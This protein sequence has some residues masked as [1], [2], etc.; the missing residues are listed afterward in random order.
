MSSLTFRTP[1]I[2]IVSTVTGGLLTADAEYWVEQVRATVRF[3]DGVREL[4]DRGVRT[5]LEV[6]PGGVLAAMAQESLGD[7]AAAFATLRKDVAEPRAVVGAAGRLHVRGIRLDWKALMPGGRRVDLPVYAFQ[8]ERYWLEAT[9]SAADV[10]SVGLGAAN[11]PLLGAA[12]FRADGEGVLLTGRI[13]L[14]THSWLAD[15]TVVGRVLLPGTAFVELALRA[16]DEVGCGRVDELIVRAPLVLPERDGVQIQVAVAGPDEAGRCAFTVYARPDGDPEWSQHATGVLAVETPTEPV[17]LAAWPPPGAAAIDVGDLYPRLAGSGYGYG[18]VF[19][20][21]RAAWHGD[22]E[23]YAEVRLPSPATGSAAAFGLHPALSDAALHALGMADLGI[24][25]TGLPFSFTGVTL[26]AAAATELRARL[27]PAGPDAISVD[28]ADAAGRPVAT[29]ERLALRPMSDGPRPHHDAL[30]RLDWVPVPPDATEAAGEDAQVVEVVGRRPSGDLA[31]DVHRATAEALDLIQGRPLDAPGRLVFVTRGAVA[32]A[33]GEDVTDLAGAAVWGLVRS[34]QAENPGRFALIDLD[35][36]GAAAPPAAVASGE[37]QIAVRGGVAHV[38]RLARLATA[39]TLIPPPVPSWRLEATGTGTVD[40]LDLVDDPA[41]TRD[42]GPGEVRVAMRAAGLNFRDVVVTLGLVPGLNGVGGEGAGVVL[43]TGPGVTSMRPGDEVLGLIPGSGGPVA[44]TDARFLTRKP[45]GWSWERAAAVPIVYLTAYYGLVDLAG[46]TAGERVLIHAA[47]GGVGFAA[48]QLA[49]HLGLEVFGTASAGKW[50][51]LR[52]NG[53]D[54][55]HIAGSR[56]LDF[57]REFLGVTGGDG[58]DVVLDCLAGEFVDA[59]LRLLPHGG[60]FLELGKTDIRDPRAV[61]ERYPGVSY[62]AYDLVEAAGPDR[63]Q[64]MLG[65]I[66]TL[67]ERGELSPPPVTTWDVR[68]AREAVRSLSQAKLVGKAVLTMPARLDPRGTVLVTGGTGTLGALAARHLVTTHGA[69]R[70]VLTSRRGAAAPG[71]GDLAAELSGMGAE[72]TV[73]A[74]DVADRESLAAVLAGIPAA[75]PLT[76]VV[77]TAG[78]VDDGLLASLT[79]ERLAAVLRP[80]VDAVVNLHEL[81]CDDELAEFV[82]FS[83][84]ASVIGAAGQGNYAAANAFLDAFARHRHALGRPATAVG[85][86]LWDERSGMTGHLT[87]TDRDRMARA[88]LL[89][90]SSDEG[91]ALF[92]AARSSVQAHALAMRLDLA[93]LHTA[94]DSVPPLLSGLVAAPGRR[95]ARAVAGTADRTGFA[96]R[97]AAMSETEQSALLTDLVCSNAATVLG[98]GPTATVDVHRPFRD[99]GFDSLTAVELRNRLGGATGLRL[100]ATAVFDH[101]TPAALVDHLRAELLGGPAGAAALPAAVVADDDPIVIVSMSCRYPGGVHT[102]ED[103]WQVVAGETDAVSDFPTDRGWDVEALYDPD[104]GVAGRTYAIEGGFLDDV[105]G[106]D[107][108]FFG[109]SPREAVAM[110]P[111]QRLLLETAWEAFERA[112]IDPVALRGSQTGVFAGVMLNDY[113]TRLSSVPEGVEG[114]LASGSSASVASGRIS[115]T[116]GLVGPAVTV[117]TA[118]SSSLVALHLAAQAL[119]QGECSLALAGGVTVMATPFAFVE[120]S[121]QRGLAADGRCKSFSSTADGTGWSEGAG[122][123]LLERRS[124]AER[125]GHEILAVVRGS[126][127]NQDG[128][129]NGLTAPNGPSQQRVIRQALA[130]A[131]LAPAD[132]DVVEAHGTGT[133]LGDPIEA[134][135][136]LA[137]YGQDRDQPLL[138]GS[139]KSNIGHTQAAAGVAGIIKMVLAMRHGVVPRTLHVDK[140]TPEVDWSSGAVELATAQVPWPAVERARRAAVSS[141]GVS[142]TNAHV[143]LE[144]LPEKPEMPKKPTGVLVPWVVS[145]KTEEGVRAQA[146]RLTAFVAERPGLDPV[147]VG[148]TLASRSPFEYRAVVGDDLVARAQDVKVVFVFPGQGS[149]WVGM[150]VELLDQSPVF[151]KSIEDCAAALSEFVDWSLVE[152]LRGGGSEFER[153]DV[154]QPALWAVM[155]SLAELWRSYGVAPDAVVGHSQGEIAAAVVAGALSHQDGARVVALRSRALLRI[156][157]A[158]GMLSIALPADE[159]GGR[160][161]GG[162]VGIAAY[163]GPN[164]VV[165]SGP[166]DALDEWQVELES[167]GVRARR[168]PVDYA[169]HSADVEI[170][171]EEILDSLAAVVPQPGRI[172]FYS[173]LTGELFDTSGLDAGYWFESLRQPVLFEQAT[174]ALTADGHGV[175]IE[176]SAHP[177]LTIGVPEIAVGSLRRDDG[178]LQRFLTS[179][180]EAWTHGVEVDW[181]QVYP[182]GRRVELPTYAFRHQRYWLDATPP[183]AAGEAGHPLLGTAVTLAGDGGVVMTGTLSLRTHPWLADHTVLDRVL[184]PGTAFVE[185]ALRAAEEAGCDRLDEIVIHAPLPLPERGSVHLQVVVAAPDESGGRALTVYAREDENDEWTRHATGHLTSGT[186]AEPPAL[187]TWPPPGAEAVA[188]ADLYPRLAEAGYGYGPVFQGLTS[189]WRAVDAVYAEVRLPL[190]AADSAAE[191]GLHPALFDAALHALGRSGFGPGTA[192][193]PFSFSGVALHATGAPAVRVRMAPAGSDAVS[194]ELADGAGRPV[195]S[196]ER[197]VVRPVSEAA[198]APSPHESLFRV[199]WVPVPETG[200]DG[201]ETVLVERSWGSSVEDVHTATAEALGLV[202][203]WLAETKPGRLVFVTRGAVAAV[204]GDDVTDPAGAAVWGLVRSAEAENPGRFALVDLDGDGTVRL[205][206]GEPQVAVRRGKVLAPRLA[207]TAADGEPVRLDPRG[208]VLVTGGTGMLGGLIARHLVSA[209]GVRNLMLISRRG[210]H[211]PGVDDLVADLAERGARA[212]VVA[213]DAA[214][215]EALAATLATIPAEHPLTAIVH[216]AGVLDDALLESTTRQRLAAVLRPKVDAAVN[217]AELTE[218]ERLA[219]FVLFSSAAAVL[220]GAGQGAYAAANAFLDAFAQQ[221]QA[222]GAIVSSLG[223]GL[224]APP[225]EMTGHLDQAQAA[226]LARAAMV[227][228][229]GEEGL[230]LFDAALATGAAHTVPARVNLATLRRDGAI[231]PLLS[232]LVARTG[233]RAASAS[234]TADPGLAERLAGMPEAEGSAYLLGLVRS[235]VAT[236]LGRVTPDDVDAGRAFKDL[237][238]DSLTAVDLRNRLGAATGLRLPATVVFDHPNATGLAG[239]LRAELLAEATGVEPLLAELDRLG[240]SLGAVTA[241]PAERTRITLRLRSLMTAWAG[242]DDGTPADDDDLSAATDDELFQLADQQLGLS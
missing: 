27:K 46:A 74:C 226:R 153:V 176:C 38:P 182:Q 62:R 186:P 202:Q 235:H 132:V 10:T 148:W 172:P 67:F 24:A 2:P 120:F 221:R 188:V 77:H 108:E 166:A 29:I 126:V 80:K 167:S 89:P 4:G 200:D 179:V 82:V 160:L 111:Q 181:K 56:T 154:V 79:P 45:A 119:R 37:P 44:V 178:G 61:A 216:T 93:A 157:G 8:H 122:W 101:P 28:L 215:R 212:T 201:A 7:D 147:D 65:E 195:A 217:L 91:L 110:D 237:G 239:F 55:I 59:S 174:R 136:V 83:S 18:P 35:P 228:L 85:W 97:L 106:F 107:A 156:A 117:D 185:L 128:A 149:Q 57:E 225:S 114:Y 134:Q 58:V 92:D 33:D 177:V 162:P 140:P 150:A 229:T 198:L 109:I 151:A 71:A 47:A 100:A 69:R 39:G 72:V 52:A 173:A 43:E 15:H 84:S 81:T 88:G 42:L 213:C 23:A 137:T 105:S 95:A 220:G 219:A 214:D 9:S 232:G 234:G 242:T 64:E 141:F 13:S 6:G 169:S 241:D 76:A 180:A 158:G 70:L 48:T 224:W 1:E 155:V 187:V 142:G 199:T 210:P 227:P 175:L 103:L 204:D 104:P 31:A 22:G 30:F 14:R 49:R 78:V 127:V 113:A 209:Y 17:T 19:Q 116:F 170:L 233:R 102:P 223:W 192:G 163:N 63:V 32:A 99:Q 66:V 159:V 34:A 152:V 207:R 51:A 144:A 135:A 131:R 164:S 145:A 41:A 161:G 36:E 16:G 90:L 94:G 190:E 184:L 183:A 230:A 196:V 68:R 98:L 193:L 189:V 168:V 129:S 171:R 238:F 218:D 40:G 11:H 21:L 197:L 87:G 125:H 208:T 222:R 130:N 25:A 146:E 5:F 203:S 53:Y 124:D 123:L 54:D 211:G 205:P 75:H 50:D 191:F 60:R 194:V 231:P 26:H 138:L 118:C 133:T 143:I 3:A 236:V 73:V 240:R 96:A 20:G 115:Y 86:G 121:R 139:I 206:V 165:V 12:V 112:G